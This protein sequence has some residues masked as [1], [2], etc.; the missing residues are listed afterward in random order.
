MLQSIRR[1]SPKLYLFRPVDDLHRLIQ[2]STFSAS[3][4]SHRRQNALGYGPGMFEMIGAGGQLGS[5]AP[6]IE[7]FVLKASGMQNEVQCIHINIFTH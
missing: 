6:E 5:V 4:N 3:L 2:T 7:E 1:K